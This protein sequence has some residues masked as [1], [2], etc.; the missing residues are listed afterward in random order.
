MIYA[1]SLV[2]Q[3]SSQA[4]IRNRSIQALT[5]AA[6]APMPYAAMTRFFLRQWGL[7]V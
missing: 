7:M 6:G 2:V 4:T 5:D 1:H 3:E